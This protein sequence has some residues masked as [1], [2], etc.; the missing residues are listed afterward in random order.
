MSDGFPKTKVDR[1][2]SEWVGGVSSIQ[3]LLL[4]FVNFAK[5]FSLSAMINMYPKKTRMSTSIFR[6]VTFHGGAP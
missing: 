6:H 4:E 2:V 1:G 3:F 5:P